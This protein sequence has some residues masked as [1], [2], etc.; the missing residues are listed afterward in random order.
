MGC[1][2][3]WRGKKKKKKIQEPMETVILE[4]TL[5]KLGSLLAVGL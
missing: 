1:G 5:I 3:P 2:N 4:S